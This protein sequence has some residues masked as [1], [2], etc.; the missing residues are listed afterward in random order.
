MQSLLR[1]S[2]EASLTLGSPD[3]ELTVGHVGPDLGL[4]GWT[5]PSRGIT[6]K[7][8]TLSQT[9]LHPEVCVLKVPSAGEQ[10]EGRGVVSLICPSEA[11]TQVLLLLCPVPSSYGQAAWGCFLIPPFPPLS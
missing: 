11:K 6:T 3:L 1:G 2:D 8:C 9:S 10:G 7:L 4:P 5:G